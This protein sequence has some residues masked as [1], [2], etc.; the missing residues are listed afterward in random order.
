MK[1]ILKTEKKTN[2]SQDVEKLKPS[3][4]AGEDIK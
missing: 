2:V 3:Y 1:V 4:I